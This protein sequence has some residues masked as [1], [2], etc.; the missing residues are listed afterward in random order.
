M[1]TEDQLV[2][3]V[4]VNLSAPTLPLSPFWAAT[5]Y[6]NA[7]FTYTPAFGRMYQY[8]SSYAR[9]MKFMR[10]HNI[11]TLHGQGDRFLLE[12]HCDYGNPG[13]GFHGQDIV[14][15]RSEDGALHYDWTFVDRVY[16]RIRAHEMKPIVE[17]CFLPSAFSR[18]NAD[19]N[20]P[21]DYNEYA[22]FI[23][24]F[25]E[26][27]VERYG[28]M[29]VRSWY[30]E[31]WNEPDGHGWWKN[32]ETFFA[33]YDYAENALHEVDDELRFGGP[34]S[35]QK[36]ESYQLFER[37]LQHCDHGLN[38]CTGRFG[39]R[40]DF[41]SVHC[42]GGMENG[43][44]ASTDAMFAAV[45]RYI[46]II[47]RYPAFK[48]TEFFNDESDIVWNGN[49]GVSVH[50]WLNF[51]NTHYA[52]GF[53]CKMIARYC[54]DVCDKGVNLTI[55]DSDNSHL[56][57]ERRLF[58]GNRSQLTP[59][60]QY[61]TRDVIKKPFFNAYVLLSHLGNE[62]WTVKSEDQYYGIK[63]GVLPTRA[64]NVLSV[65][66]WNFEDGI[67]DDMG[68]RTIRVELCGL[69]LSGRYR[70]VEYRIDQRHSTANPLW[71]EMGAPEV[72]S[73]EQA[74]LL[75][76]AADLETTGPVQE[77]TAENGMLSFTL[78]MPP[79]AVSLLKIVPA[80]I[81]TVPA[82]VQNVCAEVELG[83]DG[84]PQVF[85]HWT[86]N[87]ERDFLHYVIR[88]SR[89]GGAEETIC[90]RL[91]Q[92]TATYVDM[93]VAENDHVVYRIEAVNMAMKCSAAGES[94]EVTVNR[95]EGERY[96]SL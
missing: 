96:G 81:N 49:I 50:S 79:H 78:E 13:N 16:D 21:D 67:A 69:D 61:P 51:R 28:L 76:T 54:T 26:H 85:L 9:H 40:V 15:T 90:D 75:R 46:T 91:S 59:L 41:L 30:F 95:Q 89:N 29:E 36:E 3:A 84:K 42:K 7:D 31:A 8:L 64:G 80:D 58:S 62:R 44:C 17:L 23:K 19:P 34:A 55:V 60:G 39:T 24:A 22:A 65:M 70:V 5:G 12:S 38:Y 83:C 88:R 35:M 2:Q 73:R 53:V 4:K 66:V 48:N 74:I 47:D 77:M 27:C 10:L 72:P 86:P 57:W 52:P 56:Q 45:N 6:A 32:P 43:Y 94:K 11:L 14:A 92:N 71:H 63:Y 93:A 82:A 37:F 87:K 25:A 33:M 20:I 18:K 68:E 1:M